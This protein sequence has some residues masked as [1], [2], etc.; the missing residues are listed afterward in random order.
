MFIVYCSL[1][2]VEQI[3]SP[4]EGNAAILRHRSAAMRGQILHICVVHCGVGRVNITYSCTLPT[5]VWAQAE[6]VTILK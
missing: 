4:I 3:T 1:S 6:E 5:Y 2:T